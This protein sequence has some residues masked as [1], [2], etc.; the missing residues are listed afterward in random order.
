MLKTVIQP[1]GELL[2]ENWLFKLKS[3]P[4]EGFTC[5]LSPRLPGTAGCSDMRESMPD[6]RHAEQGFK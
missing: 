1:T 5:R 3:F 4:L 2:R 6:D